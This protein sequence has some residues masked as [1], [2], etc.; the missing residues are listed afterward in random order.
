MS[1]TFSN[2]FRLL[3][4]IGATTTHAA[5]ETFH[6]VLPL[7]MTWIPIGTTSSLKND[8]DLFQNKATNA[9]AQAAFKESIG[10][11]GKK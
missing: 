10:K 5:P 6:P 9:K 8:R 11:L 1:R 4:A 3:L 7:T 2:F